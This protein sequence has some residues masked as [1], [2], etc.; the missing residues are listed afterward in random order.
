MR[1]EESQNEFSYWKRPWHKWLILAAAILQLLGFWMNLR[2]YHDISAAGILSASGWAEYAAAKMWQCAMSGILFICFS[3]MFLTGLFVRS[4]RAAHLA[5]GVLLLLLFF[6]WGTAGLALHLFSPGAKR[7]FGVLIL[8]IALG[9]AVHSFWKYGKK[10][11][12]S[13]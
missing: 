4:Q 5:E 12:F 13:P 3:G 2:E 9:G 8:F 10:E 6:A 7:L 1:G 11:T